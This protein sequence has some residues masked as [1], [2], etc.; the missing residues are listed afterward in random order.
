VAED[1]VVPVD[2]VAEAMAETR[3]IGRRHD[4]VALCFGHAGDGN[5]HSTF[6]VSPE[7][8][9]EIRRAEAAVEDLFDLAIRLGGSVSG[10]HGIGLLKRGQLE[11]QWG[12][13]PVSLHAEIKR[14]FDPKNLLNPGKKLA[15]P[16]ASGEPAPIAVRASPRPG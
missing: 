15:S 3:A 2:R 14:V 9:D 10:E 16:P 8:D 11:K 13:R 7:D 5:L 1:I 4:L 6:L 12:A